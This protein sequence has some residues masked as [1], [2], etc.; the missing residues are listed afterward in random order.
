MKS[1]REGDRHK[2]VRQNMIRDPGG[3]GCSGRAVSGEVLFAQGTINVYT[4]KW[5]ES[6]GWKVA[7]GRGGVACFW[8]VGVAAQAL[9]LRRVGAGR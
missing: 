6:A 8:P 5:L 1:I 9:M 2:Y 3:A 4:L 7:Q